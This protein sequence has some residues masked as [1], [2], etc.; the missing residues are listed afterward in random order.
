MGGVDMTIVSLPTR[1]PGAQ[2]AQHV[3]LLRVLLIVL[4]FLPYAL[5]RA[6]GAVTVASVWV[7]TAVLLGWRD[8]TGGPAN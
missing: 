4:A 1:T 7:W 2:R 6:A 8:A 5:G 3:D